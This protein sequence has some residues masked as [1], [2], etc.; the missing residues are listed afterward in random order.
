MASRR[1]RAA[2]AESPSVALKAA[3][4]E[5]K[6]APQELKARLAKKLCAL[7]TTQGSSPNELVAAGVP[8]I[9]VTMLS[10]SVDGSQV[11][12]ATSLSALFSADTIVAA[13]AVAPLVQTMRIGSSAAVTAAAATLRCVTEAASHRLTVTKAGAIVPLIRLLRNGSTEARE[14]ASYTIAHLA[15]DDMD[16]Q[17]AVISAGAVP[18][19]LALLPSGK[20]Q[21]SAASAL[22]RL[23]DSRD[24]QDLI[25]REGAVAPLLVLLN[26]AST[27]A[28]V[29]AATALANLC[30]CN[31]STQQAVAKAGGIGPL[32]AMLPS[33]YVQAQSQGARALAHLAA[34]HPEN[35]ET[36][37]RQVSRP[38]AC[39]RTPGIYPFV[40]GGTVPLA[41]RD[42]LRRRRPR[43]RLPRRPRYAAGRHPSVGGFTHLG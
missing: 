37:A 23:C 27:P 5:L 15:E 36:I 40:D 31:C 9:L 2:L 33:R 7:A 18:M 29:A 22:S 35:Q 41:R 6:T 39:N 32:L 34:L 3:V 14:H 16:V 25:V 43:S 30:R 26:S 20:S 12:A 4:S 24:H 10:S 38:A 21:T 28:Q 1:G 17:G 42:D 13:G 8:A 19:L 11:A